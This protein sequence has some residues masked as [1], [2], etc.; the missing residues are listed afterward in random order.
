MKRN[1]LNILMALSFLLLMNYRFIGNMRHEL[2]GLSLFLLV[3]WHNS[4]NFYWYKALFRGA[5]N[6]QWGLIRLMN[7]SLVL[8]FCLTMVSGVLISQFLLPV[9]AVSG[10]SS[11]WLHSIHQGSSY[12]CFVIIGIHLGLHWQLLWRGG[13][14]W[15]ERQGINQKYFAYSKVLAAGIIAYGVYA[16]FAQHMGAMLLM[17]HGFGWGTPP[18][19]G[20]FFLDYLAIFGCYTGITHYAISLLSKARS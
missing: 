8:A 16:S 18:S 10:N 13:E 19:A 11:I 7:V 12:L 15:L 1:L 20:R 2:L 3:L 6:F 14:K 5:H 4:L 17:E 9:N